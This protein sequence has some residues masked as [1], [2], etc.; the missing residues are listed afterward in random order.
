MSCSKPLPPFT[1]DVLRYLNRDQLE[2]LSIACRP[3]KYFI[4]RYFHSSPYRVFDQLCIHEGSYALIHNNVRWHPNREHYSVLQFLDGQKCS[5]NKN[6][7]CSFAEIRPYLGPTVRIK[8]TT[9]YADYTYNLDQIAEMESIAYLWRDGDIDIR[10]YYSKYNTSIVAE[11]ILP[12]L[13]SSTVLQCKKL[14]LD[15]AHFSF[16]DHKILYSVKVIEVYYYNY[17]IDPDSWLQFLD[18]PGVKP[19]IVL[20][21]SHRE[22]A[23]NV[24]NHFVKAFSSAVSPNPFKIVFSGLYKEEL[25]EFRETNKTSGEILE[26][27]KGLPTEYQTDYY[28]ECNNY[29]LERSS[30]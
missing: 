15:N 18:Q 14:F 21:Q 7:G 9:I 28:Y 20:L 8:K 27:K 10:N 13:N 5:E 22:N 17:P 30:V 6:W 26:L 2:R 4:E 11:D 3:L 24:I 19:L 29:T 1:F 23:D 25:T 12:I 16:K